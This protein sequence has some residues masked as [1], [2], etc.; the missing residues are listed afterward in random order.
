VSILFRAEGAADP[1]AGSAFLG[2]F[3]VTLASVGKIESY[4]NKFNN[5]K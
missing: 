5:Q 1:L 2:L 4:V 3:L